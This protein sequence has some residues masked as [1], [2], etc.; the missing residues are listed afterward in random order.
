M[1]PA[2]KRFKRA[3]LDL[4]AAGTHRGVIQPSRSMKTEAWPGRDTRIGRHMVG[5]G[6]TA[7]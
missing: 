6:R 2:E 4:I 5:R 7:F 3:V 1:T